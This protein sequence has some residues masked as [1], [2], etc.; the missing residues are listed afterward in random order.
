MISHETYL[1][2]ADLLAN[3]SYCKRS[4]VGA[5]MV[6]RGN[7]ISMGYNGTPKGACNDCEDQ[8]GN[9]KPEVIHAELNAIIKCARDGVSCEGAS[10]YVSLS[11]CI[12][13]AKIILQA[14]IKEVIYKHEYR[15]TE[16]ISFLTRNGVEV[17]KR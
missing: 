10:L 8:N 5:V 14:G 9:T 11:P 17:L 13:C 2:I 1:A 6:M 3:H 16:G 12:E 4:K 15:L 7:I